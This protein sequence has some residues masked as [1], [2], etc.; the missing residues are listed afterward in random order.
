MKI[1]VVT[2]QRPWEVTEPLATTDAT[3]QEI[4]IDP[5]EGLLKRLYD[6]LSR[7]RAAVSEFDPDVILLDVYDVP[8]IATWAVAKRYRVPIVTRVV[9]DRIG[10]L[11]ADRVQTQK[12]RGNYGAAIMF[13]LMYSLSIP[14]FNFSTGLIV[15]SEELEKK[16]AVQTRLPEC[17]I[18]VVP[19]AFRNEQFNVEEGTESS[20]TQPDTITVLT[21]TN[22]EYKG[23]FQGVCDALNGMKKL[24]IEREDIRYRIAGGGEYAGDLKTFVEESFTERSRSQIEVLGFVDDIEQEYQNADIFLYVSYLEGYPNTVLEAQ[25]MQLPIVTNRAEGMKD[26]VD[27]FSTGIFIDP[28]NSTEVRDVIAHLSDCITHRT[29]LGQ[30]AKE[31]VLKRNSNDQIGITMIGALE[32]LVND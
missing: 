18:E 9:G 16:M 6:T 27:N 23:K 32:E 24:F 20:E 10:K 11:R 21:V 28:K 12:E 4:R 15:V 7:T 17:R 3:V 30:R 19:L 22:L 25:G 5:E 29:S 8:G 2:S 31:T 14:I 13:S 26:Q 1:L